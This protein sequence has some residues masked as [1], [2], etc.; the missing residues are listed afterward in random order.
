MVSP[1]TFQNL[2]EYNYW[3]RDRQL[4]ACANITK[5]QFVQALGGSFGS[6]RDTLVHLAG[7]E[8]IWCE[9]WN[10]R[11]P[12]AFPAGSDF[13]SLESM[14]HY[15]HGVE[16]DVRRF[17]GAVTEDTLHEPLSYINLAGKPFT[18]PLWQTMFHLVNHGTYHRGQVTTLLRQLGAQPA[19]VDYLLMFD[20]KAQAGGR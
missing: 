7:A 13:P 16:E 1:E 19:S 4:D 6:L 10:G 17:V 12:R 2:Y 14:K 5:E 3:A 9:R 20:M 8:W 11:S 15:W 18:Y